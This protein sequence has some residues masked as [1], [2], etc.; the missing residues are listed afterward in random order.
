MNRN[1]SQEF[2]LH[3]YLDKYEE[4]FT[5]QWEHMKIKS[6]ILKVNVKNLSVETLK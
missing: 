5:V 1:S 2:Q 4:E 6:K 3:A